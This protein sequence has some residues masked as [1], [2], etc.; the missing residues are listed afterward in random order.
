[1]TTRGAQRD[2]SLITRTQRSMG[3]IAADGMFGTRT[4]D[5]IFALTGLVIRGSTTGHPDL[6]RNGGTGTGTGTTGG[7]GTGGAD[8]ARMAASSFT[9]AD[10]I[11]AFFERNKI[12]VIATGSVLLVGGIAAIYLSTR[13]ESF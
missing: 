5:R 6:P 12:A 8:I 13:E 10:H 11:A 4:A 9:T 1:M 2:R 7:A 3:D